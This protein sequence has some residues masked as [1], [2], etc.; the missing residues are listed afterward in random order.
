M[1]KIKVAI[2]G[3]GGFTGEKIAQILA[4]H[5]HVEVSYLSTIISKPT[6]YD[7]LFPYFKGKSAEIQ[8]YPPLPG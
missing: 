8:E 2:L 7:Q 1:A 6:A 5:P 4:S 3:A